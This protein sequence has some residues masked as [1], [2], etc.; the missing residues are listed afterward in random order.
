MDEIAELRN[1]INAF[2]VGGSRES[3]EDWFFAFWLDREASHAV[4]DVFQRIEG[5]L[6]EASHAHW[7]DSALRKELASDIVPFVENTSRRSSLRDVALEFGAIRKMP[8]SSP[9]AMSTSTQEI[10]F[11]EGSTSAA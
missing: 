10:H 7:M 9:V 1:H 6:A 8:T 5:I 2:A 3:F 4:A 11:R